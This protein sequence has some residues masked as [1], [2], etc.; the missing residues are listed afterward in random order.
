MN[1]VK[2]DKKE[3]NAYN[4]DIVKPFLKWVGGK[5]QIIDTLIGY[6]PKKM[7]NY[8][9]IFLG[10]GS[11]LLALLSY[12]KNREITVDNKIYAYDLNSDLI[13]VYKNVQKNPNELYKKIKEIT[14]EYS[15]CDGDEI[16]RKPK[17]K[18]EALTSGESY[19]YWIRSKYNNLS[20][21]DKSNIIGSAMFMFLNKTCFRGVYRNDPHGFN[22]PFGHYKNPKII[23]KKTLLEISELIEN[24]K[25]KCL[26]FEKSLLKIKSGDFAYLDPPYAPEKDTSFVKYNSDGFSIEQH[27]KLF[28]MCENLRSN[29]I[30]F[31]MSNSNVKLVTDAFPKDKYLT[32]I[33]E[34]RRAIHSKNPAKKQMK[35][36]LKLFDPAFQFFIII[37]FISMQNYNIILF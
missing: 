30:K 6:Y 31:M 27:K 8:H 34:C 11:T 16:N 35:L 33:I 14:S 26:G 18:E 32:G 1:I 10:G 13:N 4:T 3:T 12:V 15:E 19:Y 36:L 28:A 17:T 9:D 21:D 20:T 37:W 7:H 24:V 5:T 22:V 29:K 25:F 23:D 2:I